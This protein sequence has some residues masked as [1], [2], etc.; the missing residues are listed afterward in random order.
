MDLQNQEYHIESNS[1]LSAIYSYSF[2]E[3][4]NFTKRIRNSSVA[5]NP[6]TLEHSSL[7]PSQQKAFDFIKSSISLDSSRQLKVIC[8]GLPGT[9]KS[10]FIQVLKNYFEENQLKVFTSSAFGIAAS[11]LPQGQTLHSLLSIPY[12]KCSNFEKLSRKLKATPQLIE[13]FK[14]VAVIILDE[15]LCCSSSLF[16]YLSDFLCTV[17]GNNEPFSGLHCI[18]VG[19]FSQLSCVCQVPL[20]ADPSLQKPYVAKGI[21]LYSDFK[22]IFIFEQNCRQKEDLEFQKLLLHIRRKKVTE[23][24]LN[25]LRSRI[26]WNLPEEEQLLFQDAINIYPRNASARK[27]NEECVAKSGNPKILIKPLQFPESPVITEEDEEFPICLD[28][29][30]V[31]KRNYSLPHKLVSGSSG[32][33]FGFVFNSEN[34]TRVPDILL[35]KFPEYTGPTIDGIVPIP[36]TIDREKIAGQV[37]KIQKFPVRLN[38][39]Q[40]IHLSQGSQYSKA[41]IFIDY[42]E[43]FSNGFYVQISRVKRLKDVCILD[44][45]ISLERFTNFHFFK[46]FK[47]LVSEYQRLGILEVSFGL[48]R[49]DNRSVEAHHQDSQEPFQEATS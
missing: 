48:K 7:T 25:V 11:N 34:Q 33:V 23:K 13:K 30:V 8:A 47:N 38:Y 4:Q 46:G 15:F 31:L 44:R 35:I 21:N 12:Y 17:R 24:D 26:Y 43:F 2:C 45:S 41:A 29:K 19:D 36:Q 49:H 32:T 5:S 27:Y 37:F 1:P 14:D 42:R 3:L 6:T 10:Y 9:G 22:D 18:L 40:S 28:S 39:S 20:T 16:A